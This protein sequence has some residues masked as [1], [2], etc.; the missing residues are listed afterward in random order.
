MTSLAL[1]TTSAAEAEAF[2]QCK[3][4]SEVVGATSSKEEPMADDYSTAQPD[5]A[6]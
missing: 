6:L 3:I 4:R 2:R 1:C 5:I